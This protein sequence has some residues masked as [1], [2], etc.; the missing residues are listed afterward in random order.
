M[1]F[2]RIHIGRQGIT[3]LGMMD[4]LQ[5]YYLHAVSWNLVHERTAVFLNNLWR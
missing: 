1:S 4:F 3:Q 2:T 5:G